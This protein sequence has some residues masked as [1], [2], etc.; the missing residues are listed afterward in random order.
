M[1]KT[2]LYK[3]PVAYA[4]EHGELD[5]YRAS[6]RANIA[7]KE[8]I[9]AIIRESFDGMHL[10]G[11]AAS[12]AL[13]AYGT[14]RVNY[15]LANTVRQKDW[16]GRFSRENKAWAKTV[17]VHEDTDAWGDDRRR[18]FVVESHPAVLDGFINQVRR[19]QPEQMKK[20]SVRK[21]L[22]ALRAGSDAF[23]ALM[24]GKSIKPRGEER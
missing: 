8:A 23:S 18:S 24:D 12:K 19:I 22:A 15:I 21:Q 11:D 10:K 20:P 14:E 13:S 16:D 4:K 7:C 1:D 6:L 3:Y 17:P 5:I 2:M 9:E